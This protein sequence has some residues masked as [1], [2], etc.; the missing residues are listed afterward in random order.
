M[1]NSDFTQY[2]FVIMDYG[3]AAGNEWLQ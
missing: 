1:Y 3:E 2:Y